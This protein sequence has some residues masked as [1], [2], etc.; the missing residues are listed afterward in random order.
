MIIR[1]NEIRNNA[2]VSFLTATLGVSSL[3]KYPLPGGMRGK[4]EG[5]GKK[6]KEI[7]WLASLSLANLVRQRVQ[8]LFNCRRSGREII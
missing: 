7:L 3:V 8:K 2:P 4:V 5:K 1:N 6:G